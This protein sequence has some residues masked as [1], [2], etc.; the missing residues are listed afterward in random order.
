MFIGGIFRNRFKD[1]HTNTLDTRE[2]AT[3]SIKKPIIFADLGTATK[4]I[5]FSSS[6]LAGGSDYP[7]YLESAYHWN[8][9]G[10][11]TASRV[12]NDTYL[13]RTADALLNFTPSGTGAILFKANSTNNVSIFG[14]NW[15]GAITGATSNGTTTITKTSHGKT[16]SVGDLIQVQDSPTTGDEGF[17]RLISYTAST[18]VV[19]RALTGSDTDAVDLAIYKDVIAFFPTD[20]TAG[21][22]IVGFS[23]Q[24]KPLVIGGDRTGT[25]TGA[26]PVTTHSLGTEDILFGGI[27]EFD[28]AAY[29]DAAVEMLE[30][31]IIGGTVDI[32]L[33]S[34][35]V[36]DAL[37]T[38]LPASGTVDDFGLITGT[39]GTNAPSLQTEDVSIS[40]AISY[41]TFLVKIPHWYKAGSTVTLRLSCGMV[42]NVADQ[43]CEVD[44]SAWVTDYANNDLSV[45]GDLCETGIQSM[46]STTFA[47]K[48]FVIDDDASG[49]VLTPG[50][51][52]QIQVLADWDDDATGGVVI[53]CI[54]HA[55]LIISA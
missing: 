6:G 38:N 44:V 20:G 33:T 1:L 47:N 3:L 18:L 51:I 49:Y 22:H 50:S 32:P 48:D 43:S 4:G 9:S 26:I 14:D 54:R 10:H 46:N 11:L 28:G 30:V 5:D 31:D 53:A 12:I 27:T 23:R 15:V 52:L 42:T 45:S 24:D 36:F 37:A 34:G 19:D 35:R 2:T 7:I 16:L 39:P 55:E 13:G 8:A 21:Q 29:F 17:Y 40:D 41:A 25:G